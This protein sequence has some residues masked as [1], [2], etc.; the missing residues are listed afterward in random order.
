[1]RRHPHQGVKGAKPRLR[2]VLTED[3]G[4]V[5]DLNR[6][7]LLA[8]NLQ[9]AAKAR[10]AEREAAIRDGTLIDAK[11]ATA[12]LAHFLVLFRQRLLWVPSR[13]RARFRDPD[14]V[15]FIRDE[16]YAAL[17]ELSEL[18]EAVA[19]GRVV[20]YVNDPTMPNGGNGDADE[21]TMIRRTS[22]R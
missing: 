6:Q 17:T 10:M 19:A 1:M 2:K 16:I 18:P 12:T 13:V 20:D 9:M 21:P 4:V 8:R 5:E 11:R 15:D 22:R 7:Y 3:D 14:L